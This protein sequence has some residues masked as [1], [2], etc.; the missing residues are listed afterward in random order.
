MFSGYIAPGLVRSG[1]L[2]ATTHGCSA[3]AAWRASSRRYSRACLSARP[4]RFLADRFGRRAIFTWSLLWYT[5]ANIIMA[6][7]D[8]ALGLNLWRFIAGIGIGVE[9]VTIGTYIS[10]LV[11][12]HV[13]AARRHFRRRSVS[14]RCR[15]SRF[16]RI[17]W[18]RTVTSDSMAGVW[19]C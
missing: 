17:C 7:Q 18:C 4:L 19:S 5:A 16:Y 10:E 15:S 3:P 14:A 2:T 12:K 11:P 9:I 13:R 6:F 1:I 8:T